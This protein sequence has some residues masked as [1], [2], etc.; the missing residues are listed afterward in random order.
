MKRFS[1]I[2]LAS[3][4]LLSCERS[5]EIEA[6]HEEL[7]VSSCVVSSRAVEQTPATSSP[8]CV[9]AL[10]SS[11]LP[12]N[13]SATRLLS[14]TN[15]LWLFDTP[16][17]VDANT[18]GGYLYACYPAGLSTSTTQAI[19]MQLQSDLLYCKN[20]V[21]FASGKSSVNLVLHHALS[22]I[23]VKV[24]NQTVIGLSIESP[25]RANFDVLTGNFADLATG[26]VTSTDSTLLI[27]PHSKE[28]SQLKINLDNGKTYTYS[29]TN[30]S[31]SSEK[32]YVYGFVLNENR[33]QLSVKTVT[34]EPWI[35]EK[36]QD[37]L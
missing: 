36:Y 24:D 9:W 3:F 33:E 10:D 4:L 34:I 26:T 11:K 1:F 23:V 14:L 12:Y 20:P 2:I 31:F 5:S 16:I 15:G 8:I 27:I 29:I 6:A 28:L 32:S 7:S 13:G 18:S 17:Y 22:R 19:D 25:I 21:E 37:Y 30:S 35:E